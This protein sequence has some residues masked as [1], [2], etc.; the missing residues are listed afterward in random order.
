MNLSKWNNFL[1]EEVDEI[2]T[3]KDEYDTADVVIPQGVDSIEKILSEKADRFKIIKKIG[4]GKFGVVYEAEFKN[5]KSKVR[6]CAIKVIVGAEPGAITREINN[7]QFVKDN[8]QNFGLRRKYFPKVYETQ[9]GTYSFEPTELSPNPPTFEYGFVVM[10]IL[11][12]IDSRIKTDLTATGGV[13]LGPGGPYDFKKI[14][15]TE[16]DKR[17]FRNRETVKEIVKSTLQGSQQISNLLRNNV[18]DFVEQVSEKATRRFYNKEY[19]I[20]N[21]G[22]E[23]KQA[24]NVVER[25]NIDDENSPLVYK[26]VLP[27]NWHDSIT[28][29]QG[30]MLFII[31]L[32]EVDKYIH[33][34]ISRKDIEMYNQKKKEAEEEAAK[35]GDKKSRPKYVPKPGETKIPYFTATTKGF[36]YSQLYETFKKNYVKPI[37]PGSFTGR[38]GRE[39]MKP[40]PES[41]LEDFPEAQNVITFLNDMK[42]IGF[43][44]FDL[45][46]DN[47]MVRPADKE[48]VIVDLGLFKLEDLAK[49][50]D[51]GD[52]TPFDLFEKR[53]I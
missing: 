2:P 46:S 19:N 29:Q 10:E 18:S 40:Q 30:K 15:F 9:K 41:A 13:T 28:G 39:I 34:L 33:P 44:G 17:L 24:F 8:Y 43:S 47:V 7:Y 12:P 6:A 25:E 32:I 51:S 22:K 48:L 20:R 16:R 1:F 21:L 14:D 5:P 27:S 31:T 49:V 23:Y 3:K 36:A 4:K 11:E 37:I 53:S 42:Q 45:H 50:E 52:T 38:F 35:Q 26:P